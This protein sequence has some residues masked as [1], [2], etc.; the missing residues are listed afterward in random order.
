MTAAQAA[1]KDEVKPAYERLI[2]WL[3][4]DMA[5]RPS[6][7]V[8]ALTLPNGADWYNASLELLTTTK[9][10]ADEIHELGL[11]EVERIQAEMD[12]IRVSTGFKGDCEGLLRVH[13]DGHAVLPAQHGRGPRRVLTKAEGYLDGD[14]RRSCRSI[15]AGCR[16]RR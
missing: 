11:K 12:K 4:E 5:Q 13:A 7:K 15:S 8:G 16:R 2:A 10:T 9:M 3:K 1:L 6:G 14:D